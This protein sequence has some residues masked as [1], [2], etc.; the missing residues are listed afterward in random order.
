MCSGGSFPRVSLVTFGCRVNQYETEMMRGL[1]AHDFH[2]VH[3][4]A[5]LYIVNACAVTSLAERKARQA[6]QRIRRGAPEAK[7]VLIGCLADAMTQMRVKMEGVD[8][9]GG[10]AWKGRIAEV[11]RQ[12]L[13]GRRGE[14]PRVEPIPLLEE[15]IEQH[16]GRVRAFLKV[17][18]G[19]DLS[20][21]FCR[22]TQVRGSSRSKPIAVAF[23]EARSL[24]VGGY[25]EIVVVGI[26]LAQYTP[27]DGDLPNLLREL[28]TIDGL[29]RVR[30][31]SL[32]P[33]GI[34][35]N[36]LRVFAEDQRACPYFHLSLQSGDDAVLRRMGRGYSAA[37]FRSQIAAI[38]H[39]TPDAT[40]GADVIVGFPGE[41]G[42]AFARTCA[43]IQEVRF[44]NLHVFRYS[45]RDG[46]TAAHFLNE[47][48]DKVKRERVQYLKTVAHAV[49]RKLLVDFLGKA[50]EIL[51]E[52]NR[53]GRWRGYTRGY[54]DVDLLGADEITIGK[55][56]CVRI[57]DIVDDHLEGIKTDGTD[58]R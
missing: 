19:C 21:T 22:T 44:L 43:L 41:D 39:F 23:S 55:E 26:N 29:R 56:V 18:D 6:I 4:S 15:R 28:L 7:I 27:P 31:G 45:R 37:S 17:Q 40:L 58:L 20:C 54:I 51:V 2:L 53:D 24:V 42:D 46:T 35:E 50:E 36:L 38:R 3:G 16:T 52:E 32:H 10:N 1:L 12:A 57:A 11:T 5:D 33:S 48:S 13:A 30:L 14:L 8:L 47:V 9:L 25:P 49:R 34:T